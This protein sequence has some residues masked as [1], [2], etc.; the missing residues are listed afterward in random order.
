MTLQAEIAIVGAGLSGLALAVALRAEGRSVAVLEARDRPG[1]RVLSQDGY[2]LGPAWIWPHNRRLLE[3]IARLGLETFP[4]YSTGRLV[5]E[6]AAG[7]IARDHA[8]AT[9]GGALRVTG[10][11][12]MLTDRLAQELGTALHLRHPVST[13]SQDAGCV[14][15]IGPG[16]ELR[17]D[18]AVLAMPPRLATG[19][20]LALPDVPTWMAAQAK[21]VAVYRTP[22]WRRFGL[23]GD[24]ISHRG[25]LAEVHD[26]TPGDGSC[27]ALFGFAMPGAAK[28]ADF[29]DRAIDQLARLFVG[30]A[31]EPIAVNI[32][33]WSDDPNTATAADLSPLTGHPAF[34]P[35]EPQGRVIIS[36]TE[37]APGEGGFLEGALEAA[38]MTF[39]QL[40]RLCA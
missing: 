35:L 15:V 19:L 12:A 11:M 34:R 31:Q 4:Q 16:F 40:E 23:N 18:R 9:M 29:Q 1:G 33:D 25:P 22:F 39:L 5:F 27:G 14:S 36:G 3:L 38:E 6:N 24:A 30:E 10:G 26:A 17:A 37:T 7:S 13:L 8:F 21:L 32:K 28:T 20:G 2:D